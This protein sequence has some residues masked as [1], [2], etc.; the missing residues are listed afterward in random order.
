MGLVVSVHSHRQFVSFVEREKR[1]D[2]MDERTGFP[3]IL[4]SFNNYLMNTP[5]TH[6]IQQVSGGQRKY[7]VAAPRPNAINSHKYPKLS[8]VNST[9]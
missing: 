2:S 1:S 8:G 7:P 9:N 3:A 6:R 5:K 4:S